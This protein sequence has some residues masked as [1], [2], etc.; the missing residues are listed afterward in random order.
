MLLIYV[1]GFEALLLLLVLKLIKPPLPQATMTSS[2]EWDK[3]GLDKFLLLLGVSSRTM[4]KD[5][6]E[7]L[8]TGGYTTKATLLAAT[9]ED[10]QALEIPNSAFQLL[11]Q[12]CNQRKEEKKCASEM[13]KVVFKFGN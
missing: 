3:N 10:F 9:Q 7:K 8:A 4:T 13:I 5:I 11:V 2:V 1:E 12:W 6:A